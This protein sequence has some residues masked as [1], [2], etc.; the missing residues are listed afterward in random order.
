MN[1]A[2]FG[3]GKFAG[4]FEAQ[5]G[6]FVVP[7]D[8]LN[9]AVIIVQPLLACKPMALQIVKSTRAHTARFPVNVAGQG[10]DGG[11]KFVP[12]LEITYVRRSG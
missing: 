1:T 4:G 5:F 3:I 2:F 7:Y 9:N 11:V 10:L 8:D 6:H 12:I